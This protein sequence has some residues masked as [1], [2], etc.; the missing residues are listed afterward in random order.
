MTGGGVEND[1]LAKFNLRIGG[2]EWK[3]FDMHSNNI[4]WPYDEVKKDFPFGFN[5]WLGSSQMK[6][7]SIP[8]QFIQG[9]F[10]FFANL[11]NPEMGNTVYW[12]IKF[13]ITLF[14][15]V[16]FSAMLLLSPVIILISTIWGGFLQHIFKGNLA[17]CIWGFFCTWALVI[18]NLFIQPIEL[19]GSFFVIPALRGG[20]TWVKSN[21][22]SMKNDGYREIILGSA[23][24]SFIGVVLYAF[25]PLLSQ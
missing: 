15:P 16:I 18:Y 14:I 12:V 7:W 5:Y 10:L 6:S 21:W 25:E 19:L 1:P 9:L 13:V 2:N 17:G 24:I 20:N 3:P 11:M 22:L 4:G 23:F 8:R